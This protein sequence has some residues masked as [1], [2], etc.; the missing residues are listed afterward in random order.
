V[1]SPTILSFAATA[2]VPYHMTGY[3]TT[4]G[5]ANSRSGRFADWTSH[6]LVNSQTRQ[7]VDWTSCGLDNSWMPS[8][9]LHA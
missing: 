7:L 6:G 4:R 5:Y 1:T 8:A 2:H 9:T 3:W